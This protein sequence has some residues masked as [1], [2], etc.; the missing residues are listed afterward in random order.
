MSSLCNMPDLVKEEIIKYCN[1]REVL[2]L[3][4]VCQDFKNFIDD[5]KTSKLP[6]AKFENVQIIVKDENHIRLTLFPY[7]FIDYFR[8]EKSRKFGKKTTIFEDQDILDIAIFDLEQVL[9][10]QKSCLE[11]IEFDFSMDSIPK[12]D[13]IVHIFPTKLRK[14]FK[15]LIPAKKLQILAFK[16]AQIMSILPLL[17]AKVLE[18]IQIKIPLV[19]QCDGYDSLG[20]DQIMETEQWKNAEVLKCDYFALG[21]NVRNIAHFTNARIS[22][23][24][25]SVRNLDILR[26]VGLGIL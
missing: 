4:Q 3:R 22:F 13:S 8:K 9:K 2:T 25:V 20:M 23:A 15:L 11:F 7:L 17:N 26:K 6:D 5:L 1:F 21:A 19:S 12:E 18:E 10:F 16:Q 14:N 24:S